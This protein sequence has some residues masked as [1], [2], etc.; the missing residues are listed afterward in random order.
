MPFWIETLKSE[1]KVE[2]QGCFIHYN[3][4]IFGC[5]IG[6]NRLRTCVGARN[7]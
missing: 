5:I 3:A 1:K 4:A 7:N 6:Q 2:H